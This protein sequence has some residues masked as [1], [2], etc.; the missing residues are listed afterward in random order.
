MTQPTCL[1][2]SRYPSLRLVDAGSAT[3]PKAA[4]MS[5]QIVWVPKSSSE[6]VYLGF[7]S[8]STARQG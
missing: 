8:T 5:F 7:S 1:T 6:L 3:I 2:M 4:Q